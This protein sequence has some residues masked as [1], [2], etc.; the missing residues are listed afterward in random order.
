MVGGPLAT[1]A[2][3]GF[4]FNGLLR[5][6]IG[7]YF[8]SVRL[9]AA[10][11]GGEGTGGT[12][13]ALFKGEVLEWAREYVPR[14]QLFDDYGEPSTPYYE[15][16][17]RVGDED[18]RAL[19]VRAPFEERFNDLEPGMLA[20]AVIFAEAGSEYTKLTGST[21]VCVPA[22][23]VW[24]GSYPHLDRSQFRTLLRSIERARRRRGQ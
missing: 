24:V 5:P 2:G 9:R 18:G 22:L 8:E 3:T 15:I 7:T 17:L 21:E 23:D 20:A 14:D 10:G 1:I 13:A 4:A 19:T 12:S 16:A 11:K 6:Y